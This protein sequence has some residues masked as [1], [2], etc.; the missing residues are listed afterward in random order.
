[1][2][3]NTSQA[4]FAL[5]FLKVLLREAIHYKTWVAVSFAVVS[6]AVLGVGLIYPKKY[7]SETIIHADQQNIIKP[8]LEGQAPTTTVSDQARSVREVVLSP[9]LLREVVVN[10]GLVPDTKNDYEVDSMTNDM[11]KRI[12]V[13]NVGQD[14]I[15][16][17]Y[18]GH[19]AGQVY[20]VVSKVT[21]LFIKD[22]YET[23]RKES[24]DAFLFIDKQV[25]TYKAQLQDAEQKLKDFT[26]NNL[27]GTE[28]GAKSRISDLRRD[29]E[30]I[31]LDIDET[32]T[33]I[34]SLE[35][36]LS[37]ESQFV[38]R[39]FKSDV[40]RER[41]VEAQQKLD[42]LKLTYT[43]DYPDVVA[44]KH[45]IEDM[46]KAITDADNDQRK[47]DKKNTTAALDANINPLYE[48]L[49]K[50]IAN[51]KVDL[52]SKRRRL[53][54]T[55]T[56]LQSE[57]ARLKRIADRQA[58]LAELTRD[59]NV[60]KSIYENMLARKEKARLSMTLDVE[61]QGVTYRIQE[62]ASYPLIPKGLRL[63]HF[64][65]MGPVLGF[66]APLGALVLYIQ[67][68]PRIRFRDQLEVVSKVPILGVVPHISSP[69]SK[70]MLKSDVIL[71]I[72][73]LVLVMCVYVAIAFA[74]HK[75][76]I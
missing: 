68:D 66:L 60:N 30:S 56:M 45:Q 69:L 52:Q 9:R 26:A 16:I 22:S 15:K 40:Y 47:A 43:D 41:L 17:Q 54:L 3:T 5:E 34:S 24:R 62:P 67:V 29:I 20:N 38:D 14:L 51:Q 49:R 70:R 23:K 31:K 18:T 44:L 4:A 55:Q 13:D 36:E 1:M 53:D 61:G 7:V 76:L 19:N 12:T 33:R 32:S 58:Q 25:K 8:L 71:L 42:T 6:L 28:E 2:N 46:K 73:F 64:V 27:D 72:S 59:Y 75:G 48:D 35:K 21:N 50:Q 63:I 11:R 10:L 39:R 37:K 65:L 57:Y 74:R